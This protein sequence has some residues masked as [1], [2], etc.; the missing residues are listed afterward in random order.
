MIRG[1]TEKMRWPRYIKT[2][3][4]HKTV[5]KY[6]KCDPKHQNTSLI[7]HELNCLNKNFTI[8]KMSFV[9]CRTIS[10]LVIT[11]Q[12]KIISPSYIGIYTTYCLH[13]RAI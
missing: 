2:K 6:S 7:H 12:S 4:K 1:N 10:L 8:T 3:S 11:N 5:E 13:L 9:M